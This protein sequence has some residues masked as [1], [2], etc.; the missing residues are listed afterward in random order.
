MP[1]LSRLP[2]PLDGPHVV[3]PAAVDR[4]CEHWWRLPPR[5]R[6]L[7]IL[8]AVLA[9]LACDQYRVV[10]AQQRWGGP[11][12]R[13]LVAIEHGNVGDRPA[14]QA[15]RLPPAMVPPDAPQRI[16]DDARLALALPR[17]AVLTR[18]HVS[19]RGPAVGLGPDLRVVPL[20]VPAGL[21]IRAGSRVD[22][23]ILAE[24]SDGSRRVARGRS[25]LSVSEPD[26]DEPVALIGLAT[27]EVAATVRGL[28]TG[29]VL[30]T[31]APR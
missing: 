4:A 31:Q 19:P 21:D 3:L 23:W 14:L 1:S 5:L 7:A 30:L 22:V 27:G 13:A 2:G 9:L 17:G 29:D 6:V 25:V 11:A 18:A 15:R 26:G 16:D 10:R 8:L 24:G 20:P 28:A 12:R